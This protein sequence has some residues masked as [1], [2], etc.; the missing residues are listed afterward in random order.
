MGRDSGEELT[1]PWMGCLKALP[2]Q[3]KSYCLAQA[4]A[5]TFK[6]CDFILLLQIDLLW[7]LIL[8]TDCLSANIQ[9][10]LMNWPSLSIAPKALPYLPSNLRGEYF[11]NTQHSPASCQTFS[12]AKYF[13]MSNI[14]LIFLSNICLIFLSNICRPISEESTLQTHYTCPHP[15]PMS[16][17]FAANYN[18]LRED[19][20][21]KLKLLQH[22]QCSSGQLRG[23]GI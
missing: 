23:Q 6:L 22:H 19:K 4:T 8:K 2:P 21:L 12:N 9:P 14:C 17:I 7:K 10:I 1:G 20:K 15:A 18:L 13:Q 11:A 16:N 5:S 3:K